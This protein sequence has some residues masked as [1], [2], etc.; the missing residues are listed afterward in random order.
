MVP[1]HSNKNIIIIIHNFLSAIE[2]HPDNVHHDLRLDNP[3]P[4][5]RAFVDAIDLLSMDKKVFDLVSTRIICCKS[6]I[7]A[8]IFYFNFTLILLLGT[9]SNSVYCY[10]IEIY[11]PMAKLGETIL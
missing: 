7:L 10:F 3:F 9:F 11:G 2:T 4:E 6:Q 8:T 5:L 1:E